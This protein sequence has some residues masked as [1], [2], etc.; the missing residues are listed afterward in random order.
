[1]TNERL[2]E[3]VA[4]MRSPDG[5]IGAHAELSEAF[6]MLAKIASLWEECARG[7]GGE[8]DDMD[9]DLPDD[10]PVAVAWAGLRA[11]GVGP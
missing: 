9:V 10:H 1:M 4:A 2:A 7:M 3:I 5:F 11:I 8:L 6:L